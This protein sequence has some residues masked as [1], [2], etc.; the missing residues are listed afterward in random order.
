MVTS[1]FI[2]FHEKHCELDSSLG[3]SMPKT[4]KFSFL[5]LLCVQGLM[6]WQH[7]ELMELDKLLVYLSF[8]FSLWI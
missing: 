1:F 4:I 5:V 8:V 3:G 7:D 6:T 2:T